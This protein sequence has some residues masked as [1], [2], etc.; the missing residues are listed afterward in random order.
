MLADCSG[1]QRSCI[2]ERDTGRERERERQRER[3][4]DRERE[5]ESVSFLV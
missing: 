3:Q 1:D 2:K 5:R 4:K